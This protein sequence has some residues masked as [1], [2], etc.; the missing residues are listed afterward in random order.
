MDYLK[1]ARLQKL[2]GMRGYTCNKLVHV[3][4]LGGKVYMFIE[5]SIDAKWVFKS[6]AN[7]I[8]GSGGHFID[9]DPEK[10]AK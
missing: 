7:Q 3:P 6:G 1:I 9:V 2:A 8:D 5:T 10:E 4:E